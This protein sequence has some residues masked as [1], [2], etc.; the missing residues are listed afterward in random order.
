LWWDTIRHYERE[1][2]TWTET[3]HRQTADGIKSHEQTYFVPV[4]DLPAIKS[5]LELHQI[6]ADDWEELVKLW[7]LGFWATHKQ[8]TFDEIN[9]LTRN[10]A[11]S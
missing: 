4:L 1:G 8:W 5:I 11:A 6:D 10:V 3:E 7:E 2:K 9:L